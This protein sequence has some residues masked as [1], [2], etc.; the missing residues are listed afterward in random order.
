MRKSKQYWFTPEFLRSA[1]PKNQPPTKLAIMNVEETAIWIEMITSL[2]GWKEATKYARNFKT[3]G[4]AGHMLAYLTVQTLR[5]ELNI[6]KFGHRLEIMAAIGDNELTLMNPFIVSIRI[7]GFNTSNKTPMTLNESNMRSKKNLAIVRSRKCLSN[8]FSIPNT[9][10]DSA[11]LKGLAMQSKAYSANDSDFR[12]LQRVEE[13]AL[14]MQKNSYCKLNRKSCKKKFM[15]KKSLSDTKYPWIPPIKLPPS[16]LNL[17]GRNRFNE[18][19][20]EFGNLT[21][22]LSPQS[23]SKVGNQATWRSSV[24]E[25]LFR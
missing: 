14:Q 19:P 15:H 22:F 20:L 1:W 4:V 17:E 7:N 10:W 6:L 11:Q 8:R 9:Y 24:K 13:T 5:S 12:G 3:N 21:R 25:Q 16:V 2:K 18:L 23:C